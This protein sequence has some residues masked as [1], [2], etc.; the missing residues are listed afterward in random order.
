[1]SLHNA[2]ISQCISKF[3]SAAGKQINDS[4]TVAYCNFNRPHT[5]HNCMS[6]FKN[7][8][9]VET[10]IRKPTNDTCLKHQSRI[11]TPCLTHRNLHIAQHIRMAIKEARNSQ[12]INQSSAEELPKKIRFN[13]ALRQNSIAPTQQYKNNNEN[14]LH[15]RTHIA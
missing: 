9:A 12:K 3:S 5:S 4:T 2:S 11:S 7:K 6:I 10:Y 1:M 14:M 13:C 8:M 15:K